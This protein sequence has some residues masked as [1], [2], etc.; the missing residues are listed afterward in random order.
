MLIFSYYLIRDSLTDGTI[1]T[2]NT[3]KGPWGFIYISVA[4]VGVAVVLLPVVNYLGMSFL[5]DTD[6][7]PTQVQ[8]FWIQES[9]CFCCRNNHKDPQTGVKL[10]CDRELVYQSLAELYL[11]EGAEAAEGS[12]LEK[13]NQLV[14]QTGA[15]GSVAP[16]S[17]S[18]I[19]SVALHV[20][21]RD[22]QQ[23]THAV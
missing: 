8:N 17:T 21:S 11:G 13:F 22:D 9:E 15:K 19:P 4:T 16:G 20:I 23:L 5:D 3:H 10:M 18:D 2:Q 1:F 14:R 6:L 7:L 12:E